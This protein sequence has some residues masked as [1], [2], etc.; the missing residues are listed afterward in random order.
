MGKLS[1]SLKVSSSG[2][3]AQET[4]Y[5]VLNGSRFAVAISDPG[6]TLYFIAS[7]MNNLKRYNEQCR[8]RL[9]SWVH[10]NPEGFF[11]F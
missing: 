1:E 11:M 3:I 6:C 9:R 5:G 10:Y 2:N 4:W 8:I 7:K